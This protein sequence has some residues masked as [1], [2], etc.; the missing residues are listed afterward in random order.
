MFQIE[1]TP[2]IHVLY[3]VCLLHIGMSAFV[4][5]GEDSGSWA[6]FG[7]AA[8]A[9][10]VVVIMTQA[11]AKDRAAHRA[12]AVADREAIRV[13]TS[14]FLSALR[15]QRAAFSTE[16]SSERSRADEK[17]MR[18][19]QTLES[20]RQDHI[21]LAKEGHDALREITA[22]FAQMKDSHAELVARFHD[23]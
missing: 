7:S 2:M 11:Q 18:F 17:H 9:V 13:M 12:H 15:E 21:N 5:Q 20:Y 10:A 1:A 14:D 19:E 22:A 6:V 16:L 23:N 4:G 3:A 8:A